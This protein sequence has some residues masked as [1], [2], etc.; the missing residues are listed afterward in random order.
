MGGT[1]GYWKFQVGYN[2]LIL[3]VAVGITISYGWYDFHFSYLFL[4]SAILLG[5]G[6][7]LFRLWKHA[8][9]AS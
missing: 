1:D 8:V 3:F 6:W 4:G 2:I 9:S 7:R 5:S